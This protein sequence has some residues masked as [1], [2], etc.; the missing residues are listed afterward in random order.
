LLLLTPIG[1]PVPIEGGFHAHG[2]VVAVGSNGFK[3]GGHGIG[4]IFVKE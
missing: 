1:K 4:K 3:E 2:D